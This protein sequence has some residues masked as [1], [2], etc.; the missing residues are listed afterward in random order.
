L[1]V[2]YITSVRTAVH[3]FP[4]RIDIIIGLFSDGGFPR[5]LRWCEQ[6]VDPHSTPITLAISAQGKLSIAFGA[7]NAPN[8]AQDD[9]L[10]LQV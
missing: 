5:N 6:T 10:S 7:T 3:S 4:G 1:K 2:I 9:N 8:I